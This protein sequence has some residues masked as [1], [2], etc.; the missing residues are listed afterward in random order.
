M[1]PTLA[2]MAQRALVATNAS[3]RV[4][5]IGAARFSD[6][7]HEV[8]LNA[9]GIKTLRADLLDQKQLDALP[10]APNVLYMPA[11]K[12]GST[13]QEALTWAMNTY[14]AGM[15]AQRFAQS[16]IVAFSTGNVYGLSPIHAGGSTET[17]PLDPKGDYAQSC[18]GRERMFEHFSR[19]LNIPVALIRLNYATEMRYGVMVD[20]AQKVWAGEPI[21]LSM[22]HFNAIWQGDANAM[23]LASFSHVASPPF[24]LNVVGS[25]LLNVREVCQQFGKLMHKPPKFIG[26][27]ARDALI[28]NGAKVHKLFGL[29]RVS[30]DTLMRWIAHWVMSGGENLG[31]PTHFETRDGKY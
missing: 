11:M 7:A 17:S 4:S 10:D 12:F 8:A 3:S 30:C 26:E 27:E 14:L 13:G 20:M 24:V 9:H 31:K 15:C 29:P 21:D 1:G 5:V 23:T 28:S 25:E 19:T 2:R 6:P 16:K 18:L 22:G